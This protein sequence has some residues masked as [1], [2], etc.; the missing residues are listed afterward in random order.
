MDICSPSLVVTPPSVPGAS[1]LRSLMLANVPRIITSWLP[2]RG[3]EEVKSPRPAPRPGRAVRLDGAGRRDV[4]GGHRVAQLG[5]HP[6]ADDVGDGLGLGGHP[7]E[8]RR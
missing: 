2:R 3:A 5:Q 8:V 6:R 7:V 1:W 4:V